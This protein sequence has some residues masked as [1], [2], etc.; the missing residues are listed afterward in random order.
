[1]HVLPGLHFCHHVAQC[2]IDTAVKLCLLDLKSIADPEE[3]DGNDAE[4]TYT[5]TRDQKIEQLFIHGTKIIK[6]GWLV[7][8]LTLP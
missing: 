6:A 1:M 7:R 2:I 8:T 3:L 5:D 4:K